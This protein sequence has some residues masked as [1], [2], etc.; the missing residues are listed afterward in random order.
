MQR[1][2]CKTNGKLA[3]KCAFLIK[4]RVF[5]GSGAAW[6]SGLEP[7]GPKGAQLHEPPHPFG[8]S[9]WRFFDIFAGLFCSVF[10]CALIFPTLGG[11]GAQRCPKERFWEV[12]LMP[13]G[14]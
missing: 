4:N 10:S 3:R 7:G 6:V 11:L 2:T 12:I 14:G 5:E 13:F 8:R 9:F 1:F